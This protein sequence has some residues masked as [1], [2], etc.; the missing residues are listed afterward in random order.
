[1]LDQY[2]TMKVIEKILSQPNREF[3]VRELASE[4]KISP[5]SSG[6]ALNY[7]REKGIVGWRA[8]GRTHQYRANLENPLCRQ[9]KILLGLDRLA[10]SGLISKIREKMPDV[11]S[12]L[13]YGSFAKG[14]YDER[15][16][17]DILLITQNH[18][19]VDLPFI[20]IDKREVNV[21]VFSIADWKR[22]AIDSKVFYENVIYDSIVLCGQRPV[23]H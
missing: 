21:S 12:I 19:K 20:V 14:T 7:M 4:I 9:W 5:A 1:M 11:Q 3:S 22:K 16:D 17:F 6:S 18:Q 23:V 2:T 10:D 13:L 8:V 15:S